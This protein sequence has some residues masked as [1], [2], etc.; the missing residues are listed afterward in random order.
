MVDVLADLGLVVL[1]A[2]IVGALA[3]RFKQPSVVGLLLVG[4]LIGPTQLGLVKSLDSIQVFANIGSMLLLFAIGLEFSVS[5]LKEYGALPLFIESLKM[6]FIFFLTYLIFL[7]VGFDSVTALFAGGILSIS[8]TALI[9]KILNQ[10]SLSH[11]REVPLLVAMLVIEDIVGV[12]LLTVF[13]GISANS[14]ISTAFS[15]T[16]LVSVL[17]AV[18]LFAVFFLI[19]SKAVKGILSWVVQ[20]Q[21]EETLAFASISVG[22][23][24][25]FA[26]Q[27]FNLSPSIGAF[28]AGSLIASLPEAKEFEK[29]VY[30]LIYAFSALFFISIGMLV[31]VP[32]ILSSM[33]FVIAFVILAMLLIFGSVYVSTYFFGL[34]SDSSAFSGIAMLSIGEFSLLIANK[35]AG[36]T[37]VD[38]IGLTAFLVI[39]TTICSTIFLDR[40][41][42][43]RIFFSNLMPYKVRDKGRKVSRY[44]QLLFQGLKPGATVLTALER[45]YES[46]KSNLVLLLVLLGGSFLV[47]KFLRSSPIS[48]LGLQLDSVQVILLLVAIS[49]LI[50]SGLIAMSFFSHFRKFLHIIGVRKHEDYYG[51]SMASSKLA[52]SAVL[53]IA[54]FAAVLL[55]TIFNLNILLMEVI[56]AAVFIT[57]LRFFFREEK[58]KTIFF[59]RL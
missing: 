46:V 27:A 41:S 32:L 49:S 1:L 15:L 39:V 20:Y 4:A 14:S 13:A 52:K 6:S 16:I 19:I 29:A 44:N 56:L 9:V 34:S 59:D 11:R 24:F 55:S 43:I 45:S 28:L 8:S 35:S 42:H 7:L 36:L 58:T 54:L 30:P 31:N 22:A 53:F 10:K 48:L 12:F 23:A 47:W 3:I 25:S 38:F 40:Y 57:V 21:A 5:K 33:F 2:T 17:Q 51:E 37:Q 26:A 50:L 18:L